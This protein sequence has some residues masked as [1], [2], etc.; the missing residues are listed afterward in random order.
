MAE[1]CGSHP[2]ALKTTA[3]THELDHRREQP[4]IIQNTTFSFILLASTLFFI[5]VLYNVVKVLSFD[6][7]PVKQLMPS[8][9]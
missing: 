3:R 2:V 5:A 9:I 7:L 8:Q 4:Q 6:Y 1:H